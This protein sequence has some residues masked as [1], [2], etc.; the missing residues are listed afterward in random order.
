MR[1]HLNTNGLLDLINYLPPNLT[2][3]ELGCYTGEST[4]MFLQSGK[5]DLLYAIDIWEDDCG[6]FKKINQEH[7]FSEVEKIFDNNIKN[8]NVV[9]L[10]MNLAGALKILPELDLIYID[11][12]HDYNYIREDILNSLKIVKP[13]GFICGHDYV[14]ESPGVIKAVDEFFGSPDILFSDGS[15]LVKKK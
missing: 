14:K 4:I 13:S 1:H 2:M 8:M 11:A 12:N 3:A 10:K 15:W 7:D 6:N 9:K 5:I